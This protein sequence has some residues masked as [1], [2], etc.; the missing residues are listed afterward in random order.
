[1]SN[2]GPPHVFKNVFFSV[3]KSR[4]SISERRQSLC[5][6]GNPVEKVG[7]WSVLVLGTPLEL[8]GCAPNNLIAAS[9]PIWKMPGP[10]VYKQEDVH[11]IVFS[12]L[13]PS[14]QETGVASKGDQ[15][16]RKAFNFVLKRLL[17]SVHP[18]D[19]GTRRAYLFD[20]R[21]VIF[22]RINTHTAR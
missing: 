13:K 16:A 5:A 19:I 6:M 4:P 1:M 15:V 17:G 11:P 7:E 3:V 2:F 14:Q 20:I 22:V 10:V 18:A 12:R 8:D 21:Y 9:H